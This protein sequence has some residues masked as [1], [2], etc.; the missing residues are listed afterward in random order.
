M[1]D[2]HFVRY[3][4]ERWPQL[5]LWLDFVVAQQCSLSA[6]LIPIFISFFYEEMI[7]NS[8]LMTRNSLPCQH[9]RG[10]FLQ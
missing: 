1:G 10:Q 9:F 7:Q 2:N 4:P 5:A 8:Y 3:Q 6:L